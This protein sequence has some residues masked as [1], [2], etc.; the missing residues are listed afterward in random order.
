MTSLARLSLSLLIH[1][2]LTSQ[3]LAQDSYQKDLLCHIENIYGLEGGQLQNQNEHPWNQDELPAKFVVDGKSGA[4]VGKYLTTV[5][6]TNTIITDFG[7]GDNSFNAIA[8][9][10]NKR[11]QQI[12][13]DT[14]KGS[15]DF[16][17]VA[18]GMDVYTGKCNF[19]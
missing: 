2:G 1:L 12:K 19:L 7:L 11:T 8:L 18:L 6:A 16:S 5:L 4:I 3:A 14:W 17:F 10:D 15:K 13:I 9:F